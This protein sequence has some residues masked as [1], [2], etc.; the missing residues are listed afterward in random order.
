MLFF[1]KHTN[2]LFGEEF[3]EA[4]RIGADGL[5]NRQFVQGFDVN[6]FFGSP[7]DARNNDVRMRLDRQKTP[8]FNAENTTQ[9]NAHQDKR[10]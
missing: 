3:E 5:V 8:H 1:V 2:G 4:K 7:F 6:R 10:L 9:R